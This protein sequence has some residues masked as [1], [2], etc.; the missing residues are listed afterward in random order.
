MTIRAFTCSQEAYFPTFTW[1]NSLVLK[2]QVTSMWD[3]DSGKQVLFSCGKIFQKR[4][5]VSKENYPIKKYV[6]ICH[7]PI[8]RFPNFTKPRKWIVRNLFLYSSSDFLHPIS[9]V[10]SNKKFKPERLVLGIITDEWFYWM[11]LYNKAHEWE[12]D[13]IF[14]THTC[15]V[16]G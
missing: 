16:G 9:M 4:W 11:K 8:W 6:L 1:K 13:S 10:P 15:N 5:F 14:C 2:L 12:N 7:A 3:N